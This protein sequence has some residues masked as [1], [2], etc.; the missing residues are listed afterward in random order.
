[1]QSSFPVYKVSLCE[2][3]RVLRHLIGPGPCGVEQIPA[4]HGRRWLFARFRLPF[5]PLVDGTTNTRAWPIASS[6]SP[7]VTVRRPL[8]QA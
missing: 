8:Y 7:S 5:R 3:G 4:G 2:Q 1:M 6:C